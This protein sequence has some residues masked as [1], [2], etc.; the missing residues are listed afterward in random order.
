VPWEICRKCNRPKQDNDC[1]HRWVTKTDQAPVPPDTSAI[2]SITPSQIY[3]WEGLA[4]DVEITSTTERI[5]A[6]QKWY[7]L[8]GRIV[9]AKVE[10]DGDIHLTLVDAIHDA[11]HATLLARIT[12]TRARGRDADVG[13]IDWL[14]EAVRTTG[15]ALESDEH[16]VSA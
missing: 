4:P 3:A 1:I 5:P 16:V 12:R 9:E 11:M 6:E 7:A 10:A 15:E 13:F 14:D 8:T 2:Q